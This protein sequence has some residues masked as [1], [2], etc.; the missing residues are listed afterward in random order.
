MPHKML[1]NLYEVDSVVSEGR[2]CPKLRRIHIDPMPFQRMNVKLAVQVEFFIENLSGNVIHGH[3]R[4]KNIKNWK[5]FQ[6]TSWL[7]NLVKTLSL[8]NDSKTLILFYN[9]SDC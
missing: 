8:V 4:S 1:R 3:L 9:C 5:K 2:L 6:M 7:Q